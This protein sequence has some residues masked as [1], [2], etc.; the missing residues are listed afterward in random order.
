MRRRLA[1]SLAIAGLVEW[2]LAGI[3]IGAVYKPAAQP[4]VRQGAMA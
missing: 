1:G 4:R 3:V 2:T